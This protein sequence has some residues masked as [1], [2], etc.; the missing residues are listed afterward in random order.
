MT[1][2]IYLG[3]CQQAELRFA[4]SDQLDLFDQVAASL[5][6]LMGRQSRTEPSHCQTQP[7]A[8]PR[9]LAVKEAAGDRFHFAGKVFTPQ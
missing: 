3:C 4:V 7:A 1:H 5:G 9:S 2:S 8:V 6:N